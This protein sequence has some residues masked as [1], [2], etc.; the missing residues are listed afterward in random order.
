M[1]SLFLSV[2]STLFRK[3]MLL[4]SFAVFLPI[5]VF[6]LFCYSTVYQ[7]FEK[8]IYTSNINKLNTVKNVYDVKI[9][10]LRTLTEKVDVSPSMTLYQIQNHPDSVVSTLSFLTRLLDPLSDIFL[11]E[12][13]S[14]KLFSS[15][16]TFFFSL[17]LPNYIASS[18]LTVDEF[19]YVLNH[20][21]SVNVRRVISPNDQSYLF[22]YSPLSPNFSNPTRTIVFVIDNEKLKKLF[23]FSVKEDV[24]ENVLVFD[25]NLQLLSSFV[26]DSKGM[27]LNQITPL[28]EQH[29]GDFSDT[30]HIDG[31]QLYVIA[32]HSNETGYYYVK[33]TDMQYAM[34]SLIQIKNWVIVV[35]S[36]ML[37]IGA[38]IIMLGLKFNYFPIRKIA[39]QLKAYSKSGNDELSTI[40][41]AVD[42]LNQLQVEYRNF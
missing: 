29:N 38:V 34:K 36:L 23:N 26:P 9:S 13:G 40:E 18:D 5:L 27:V 6:F 33:I 10:E 22:Y 4:Y 19:Y 16:G 42:D 17:V 11:Y 24:N 1:K 32:L 35:I 21:D 39:S 25:K 41:R 30:I 20:A 28:L 14:N 8:E 2:K 15:S 31:R 12:R 37:A 3:T 7:S